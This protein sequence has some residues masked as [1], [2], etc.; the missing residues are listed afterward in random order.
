MNIFLFVLILSNN[1]H[2]TYSQNSLCK[3]ST[4]RDFFDLTY[5]NQGGNL[6]DQAKRIFN[7]TNVA[8]TIIFNSYS[9]VPQNEN[10]TCVGSSTASFVCKQ[11]TSGHTICSKERQCQPVWTPDT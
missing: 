9:N 11:G 10:E 2:T 7:T 1:L 5:I 6:V 3:M 4:P 8:E